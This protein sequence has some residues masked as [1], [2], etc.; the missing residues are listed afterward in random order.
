MK[1]I[2]IKLPSSV[3]DCRPD[4]LAKW[5]L[6]TENIKDI[7]EEDLL[8]MIEF[9][10]QILSIFS[11]VPVKE[12]K[13]GC[14]DDINKSSNA[15]FEMLSKYNYE[16]PKGKVTIDGVNY[17]FDTDIRAIE[18]GQIIDLKLIE[19]I[20]SDP[21]KAIAICYVEEGMLYCQE[22][23]RGKVINPNE[24]RYKIFK[25]KFNGK[26]FLD[27]FG[28]FLRDYEKRKN[29]IL[30]IQM[31]RMMMEQ[32]TINQ[33]LKMMTGSYGH[34]YSFGSQKTLEQLLTES[35]DNLT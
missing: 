26:E 14:I 7:S 13:R 30:G 18:T 33:Q 19:D 29:A 5:L 34:D 10:C 32:K 22:D 16:E 9:R 17:V 25:E 1:N 23:A 31:I 3:S 15:L 20:A 27:F 2:T 12:I 35:H 8:G 11:D 6:I 21:V 28:F 4:Q 24:K